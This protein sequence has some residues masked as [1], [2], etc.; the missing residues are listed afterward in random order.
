[1]SESRE[2]GA[3]LRAR[4]PERGWLSVFD[5]DGT[6]AEIV[7]RP[8]DARLDPELEPLV[9]RLRAERG[10]VAVISGRDRGAL[11]G[12]IPAGWLAVGSYGLEGPPGWPAGWTLPPGFDAVAARARL[13]AAT[14]AV[15]ELVADGAA[16]AGLEGAVLEEKPW[17]L[18]LHF[19]RSGAMPEPAAMAR[20]Q[21]LAARH[22]LELDRGRMVV[23]LRPEGSPD[24]GWAVRA[25]AERLEP[26]AL[27]YF[28]DDLG[29][30]PAFAATRALGRALPAA[31][32]GIASAETPAAELEAACDLVLPDRGALASLLTALSGAGG[33]RS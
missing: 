26:A 4:F 24:K 5:F 3:A 22:H 29:D 30:L 16:G 33:Q 6:L 2:T 31:A 20:L 17:G 1:V 11:A 19:R 21:A 7:A 25:L 12:L 8:E 15:R 13:S 14:A 23:E 9:E 32:V 27:L 28:G 10:T 18:S